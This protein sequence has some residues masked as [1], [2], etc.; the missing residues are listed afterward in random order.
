MPVKRVL[1]DT[2]VWIEYLRNPEHP[3]GPAIG[4]WIKTGRACS[5]GLILAELIQGA[6]GEND[7]LAIE[8]LLAAARLLNPAV[9]TWRQAGNLSSQLRKKGVTIHLFDCLL[10]ALAMENGAALIS[11]DRHFNLIA[12]HFPLELATAI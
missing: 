3:S 2:S 1:V 12:A 10:A 6:Q 9:G 4:H 8:S 5:T 11:Y 7:L